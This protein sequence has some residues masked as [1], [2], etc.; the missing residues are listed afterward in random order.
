MLFQ[1]VLLYIKSA[2]VVLCDG[3]VQFYEE[4]AVSSSMVVFRVESI[5]DVKRVYV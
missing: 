3:Y 1:V 4:N 2:A 5:S